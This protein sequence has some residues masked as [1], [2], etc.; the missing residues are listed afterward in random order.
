MSYIQFVVI[1]LTKRFNFLVLVHGMS[2]QALL[3]GSGTLQHFY[4]ILVLDVHILD[5]IQ[6]RNSGRKPT[7]HLLMKVKTMN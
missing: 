3:K 5:G 2:Q 4:E 7:M 1:H 6:K